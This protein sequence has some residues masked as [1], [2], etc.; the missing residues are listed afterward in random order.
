MLTTDEFD[1]DK[2]GKNAI[3]LKHPLPTVQTEEYASQ[4]P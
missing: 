2:S 1:G 4:V 3:A